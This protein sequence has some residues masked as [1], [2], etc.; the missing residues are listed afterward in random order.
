MTPSTGN[1]Q[2]SLRASHDCIKWGDF[3]AYPVW[4]KATLQALGLVWND[5]ENK[6][7]FEMNLDW[8]SLYM[9]TGERISLRKFRNSWAQ[10]YQKTGEIL[11]SELRIQRPQDERLLLSE[12][13]ALIKH[14]STK[15]AAPEP[16]PTAVP[17]PDTLEDVA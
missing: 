12:A 4:L 3:D 7:E 6:A 15:P 13:A 8:K 16:S 9:N 17:L 11:R 2:V 14:L 1:V 5:Q 10:V